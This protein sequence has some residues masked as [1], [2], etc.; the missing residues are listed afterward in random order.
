MSF[1]VWHFI[2]LAIFLGSLYG[3]LALDFFIMKKIKARIDQEEKTIGFFGGVV[4]FVFPPIGIIVG[5]IYFKKY[6]GKQALILSIS[7]YIYYS[8][9]YSILE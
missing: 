7:A 3:V 4:C 1:S 2:A 9:I 6:Y 5:L 8:I